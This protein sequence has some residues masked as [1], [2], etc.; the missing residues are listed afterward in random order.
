M[1]KLLTLF[2]LFYAF[3]T[4]AQESFFRGNN[5]YKLPKSSVNGS[6]GTFTQDGLILNL[7][8]GNPASYAGTGTTWT[9]LAPAGS[10]IVPNF[11]LSSG[12]TYRPENGGTL[13]F[14]SAGG[15]VA[16]SNTSFGV[17]SQFT[18]EIWVNIAGT[19][20]EQAPGG[21][22]APCLFSDKYGGNNDVNMM[23]AYNSNDFGAPTNDFR[24]TAGINNGGNWSWYEPSTNYSEIVNNWIQIVYIYD[25]NTTTLYK[26]GISIG[27][28]ALNASPTSASLGYYI[29]HRWD[30]ND[31]VFGDYSIVNMYNR[32]LTPSE[33]SSNFAAVKSRFGL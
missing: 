15:S 14:S 28:Q 11:S 1:K 16:S 24:F 12:I 31:Y 5:N 3:F 26:N 2:L 4:Q 13:R 18:L 29:G 27:S 10:A 33:V 8:A 22:Y 6:S 7:D 17:L 20:G 21:N 9:N 32:P 30:M 19:I 23:L 25:G